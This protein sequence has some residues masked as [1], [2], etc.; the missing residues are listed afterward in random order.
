[1]PVFH[2]SLIPYYIVFGLLCFL[3]RHHIFFWDT[4]QLCGKQ[5]WALYENGLFHWILP[6]EIDSGHPPL[7]GF[8]HAALW[9]LFQPSLVV[10]HLAMLPFLCGIVYFFFRIGTY[11]LD[12]SRALFLLPLL[13]VDPVFM[14]QAIL[15]SPDIVLICFM[16]MCGLGIV[17]K[18]PNLACIAALGLGMISMRG[19]MVL[20]ALI[21]FDFFVKQNNQTLQLRLFKM[22][23]YIPAIA[24]VCLFLAF[25][26]LKTGWLGHHQDS[27]WAESF[28]YVDFTG[29][30]RNVFV[31]IWRELD[32]GRVF[33]VIPLIYL[34]Y[35][36][37]SKQ[38]LG[39]SKE[40]MQI[41]LLLTLV[42]SPILIL[43]KGLVLHRYMLPIFLT[44]SVLLWYLLFTFDTNKIIRN[45]IWALIMIGMISGNLWVYPRQISQGWDST[46][47]HIPY[48]H[49][50]DQMTEY[51]DQK[52]ISL[53]KVGTAFPN[54]G[55]L[56][57]YNPS[58]DRIG[59]SAYNLDQDE[60]IFYSN[61]FNDF[62]DE[63]LNTLGSAEWTIEKTLNYYPVEIIL[64]KKNK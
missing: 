39:K 8:Y 54:I 46:L 35:V 58:Q 29:G 1:M 59:F 4:Y 9:K 10:S 11:Y 57:Y 2:K 23:K 36:Q 18:S 37:C 41:L 55:P 52:D 48:Y 53:Q 17:Q 63:E 47:G 20:A 15:A 60:Y 26:Y 40:L 25:H 21:L 32:F 5:A 61:I 33:L 28:N 50:R 45:R 43:H 30:L 19:M 34:G 6:A 7:F 51:L 38:K 3:C 31:Y 62:T 56:K 24:I 16:L 42:I 12:E 14:G 44:M 13:I 49:L 22:L 64:Y 27:S